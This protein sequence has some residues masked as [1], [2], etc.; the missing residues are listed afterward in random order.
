MYS[1]GIEVGG[2]EQMAALEDRKRWLEHMH[3]C[4]RCPVDL[5]DKGVELAA[6]VRAS[7]APG[8][9]WDWA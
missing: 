8:E 2:G 6:A 5:C 7:L 9:S 3:E 4:T 1:D